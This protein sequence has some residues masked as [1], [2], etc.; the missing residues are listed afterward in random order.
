MLTTRAGAQSG[1]P[2]R[3]LVRWLLALGDVLRLNPEVIM[4]FVT[5]GSGESSKARERARSHLL[6]DNTES[7]TRRPP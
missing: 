1:V 2:S 6:P 7:L 5:N 3:E 4:Q